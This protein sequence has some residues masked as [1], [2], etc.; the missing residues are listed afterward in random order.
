MAELVRAGEMAFPAGLVV[1]AVDQDRSSFA[2]IF[3]VQEMVPSP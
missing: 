1:P 2:A 3:G